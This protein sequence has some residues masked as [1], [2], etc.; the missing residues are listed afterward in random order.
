MTIAEID[1]EVK[2]VIAKYDV[3]GLES[4]CNAIARACEDHPYIDGK[5]AANLLCKC[6]ENNEQRRKHH[7]SN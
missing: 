7:E 2:E 5:Y 4:L 3:Y 1:K 6:F